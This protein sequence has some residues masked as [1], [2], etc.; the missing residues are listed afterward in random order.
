MII[1]QNKEFDKNDFFFDKFEK[2]FILIFLD[3][4]ICVNL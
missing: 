2:K 4:S 1:S 3:Q